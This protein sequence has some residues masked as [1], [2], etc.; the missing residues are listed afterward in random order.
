MITKFTTWLWE[1]FPSYWHDNDT[2]I[3]V[4]G[5]GTAERLLC[6]MGQEIDD[7]VV[8][9]IDDY[10]DLLNAQ[11]TPDE[12]LDHISDVLGNPPKMFN[13]TAQYRNILSYIVSV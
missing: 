12:F 5:Q 11:I 6:V 2:N 9:K 13:N 3:D 10:L 1:Q 8:A 4:N 7:E